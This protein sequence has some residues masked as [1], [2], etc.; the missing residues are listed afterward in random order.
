M[1]SPVFGGDT[2]SDATYTMLQSVDRCRT[3]LSL[4]MDEEELPPIEPRVQALLA[5]MTPEAK[6]AQLMV[7]RGPKPGTGNWPD[8]FGCTTGMSFSRPKAGG[9]VEAMSTAEQ[10][11]AN[12]ALQRWAIENTTYESLYN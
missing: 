3:S 8:G 11:S 6:V 4:K 9:Q 12:D 1:D 10:I 5:R 7:G 2:K